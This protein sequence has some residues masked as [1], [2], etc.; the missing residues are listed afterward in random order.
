MAGLSLLAAVCI[1]GAFVFGMLLTLLG[2]IKLDLAKRLDIGEARVG[3]L[4]SALNLALIPMMLLSGLLLDRFGPRGVMALGSLL[5]SVALFSLTVRKTYGWALVSVLVAGLGGAC[6]SSS[7]MVLMQP[8]FFPSAPEQ[9]AAALNLGNVFFGLG[10]LMTPTL[11]EL[12]LRTVRFR[13][14]LGLLALLAL[15]P[16]VLALF[17]GGGAPAPQAVGDL[18]AV[19][20]HPLLW[21]AGLV[22]FLYGPIEFTAGTWATTYLTD[23]GY[24]PARAAWLLSAFWLVFLASRL[25]MAILQGEGV[26]PA[27]GEAWLILVLALL[28]AM[29][30]GNLAGAASKRNAGVGLLFLGA[31]L[32]PIF[33][34]LVAVVFDAF[35]ADKGTA[36][37]AVYALGSVGS[38]VL[39]PVIG[40]TA[41]R[42]TVQHALRIPTLLALALM[43]T[44]LVLGL[45]RSQYP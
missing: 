42:T 15:V 4:L 45:A 28:A 14:T 20:R 11:A 38:L 35:P 23:Q 21:I 17:V 29:A 26:L 30:L 13:W 1:A 22:F 40:A 3:G 10:C 24:R 19:L 27:Q 16:A 12:L 2:S 37:G 32:G 31:F 34:T 44:A 6:L 25:G 9:G 18:A 8:A 39:A 41:R 33:P 7:S 5:A 43:L 36:F